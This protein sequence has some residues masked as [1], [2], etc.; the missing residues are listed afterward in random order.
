M[1]VNQK[2][3]DLNDAQRLGDLFQ[4]LGSFQKLIALVRGA[5]NR[6]K[7]CFAFGHRG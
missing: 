5:D 2:E 4:N 3:D 1:P 7:A 6:A